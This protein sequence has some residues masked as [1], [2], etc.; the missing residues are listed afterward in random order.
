MFYML[1]TIPGLVIIAV[2]A[3][4]GFAIGTMKMPELGKF[5]FAKKTGGENLDSIIMRFIK[6]KTK[7]RKIYVYKEGK[8]ND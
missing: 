4:I 7:G 1:D 5:E 3:L 6:F 8:S 2:P